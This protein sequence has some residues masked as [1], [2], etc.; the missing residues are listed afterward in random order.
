MDWTK[1]S[2]VAIHCDLVTQVW[3]LWVARGALSCNVDAVALTKGRP[4]QTLPAE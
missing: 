3:S 4:Y 2:L 1:F